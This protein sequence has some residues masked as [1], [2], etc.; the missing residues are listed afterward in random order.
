MKVEQA[1][2]A[3]TYFCREAQRWISR[4]IASNWPD[5]LITAVVTQAQ[6][7]AG[8]RWGSGKGN[9]GRVEMANEPT[10]IAQMLRMFDMFEAVHGTPPRNPV[11]A[12]AKS[13]S[14]AQ[15]LGRRPLC[16]QLLAS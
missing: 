8:T 15:L 6:E 10:K 2:T 3:A 5:E 13:G 14:S 7:W 11:G 12:L 9:R 16:D 4:G 1:L